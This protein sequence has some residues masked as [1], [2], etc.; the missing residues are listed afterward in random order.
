[1]IYFDRVSKVYSPTSIALEEVS[2][3]VEPQEFVS[4]VGQSGAGKSTLLKLLLAEEKPSSGKVFF[5]S[6]DMHK[7]SNGDLPK[8]RR[9]MGVVFQDYKLLPTKTAYENIAFAMEA[10]DKTEEEI[11]QDVPQVLELVGLMDKAWHFPSELS[12]GE[13]QRVAIARA[14]V[15]RPDVIIA[16][17]PTGNLDP[18]NT[19]EIINLLEKINELGTTVVLATHDKEVINSLKRRVITLEKGKLVR[20]EKRG[21]YIL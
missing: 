21:R 14:I 12:G 15:N 8:V 16:D 9:R 18:I 11:Q 10:S 2:F 5:E 1:M 4:L 13:L 6:L 20:D 3:T 17:E 19:W 7:V